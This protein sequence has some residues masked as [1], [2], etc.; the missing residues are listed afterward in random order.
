MT[1]LSTGPN[2]GHFVILV[3]LRNPELNEEMNEVDLEK[4]L[5]AEEKHRRRHGL[6]DEEEDED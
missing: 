6:D 4:K 1:G 2:D 3:G 5:S